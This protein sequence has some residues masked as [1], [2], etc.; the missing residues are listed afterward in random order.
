MYLHRID[1]VNL[2]FHAQFRQDKVQVPSFK[3]ILSVSVCS[4]IISILGNKLFDFGIVVTV[5]EIPGLW[6]R[7]YLVVEK[8]GVFSV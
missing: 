8:T 5:I 6:F 3:F 4:N 7:V 1:Q 2:S